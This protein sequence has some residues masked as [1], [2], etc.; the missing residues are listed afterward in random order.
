MSSREPGWFVD[1]NILLHVI[2]RSPLGEHILNALEFRAR[3]TVSSISVVTQAELFS[4][5]RQHHWGKPKFDRLEE[6]LNELVIVDVT[7]GALPIIEKYAEFDQ[8]SHA[9]GRTMGKNDLWIAASAAATGCRLLTTDRDF[10][11]LSPQHLKVWWFD[12]DASEWASAPS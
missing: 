10:D 1:T 6:L 5:G 7:A 9:A 2:R 8:L 3:P 4:L 11:H 12:P